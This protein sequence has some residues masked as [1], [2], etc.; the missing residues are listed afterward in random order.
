M[1]VGND[2]AVG[3]DDDTRTGSLLLRG[4]DLLLALAPVALAE[5]EEIAKEIIEWRAWNFH[6]LHLGVLHIFYMYYRR[7]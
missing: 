2:V 7:Q 3:R 6:R 4:L 1:I 5:S